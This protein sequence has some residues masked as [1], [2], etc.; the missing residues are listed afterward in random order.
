LLPNQLSQINKAL[1]MQVCTAEPEPKRCRQSSPL[2]DGA[3]HATNKSSFEDLPDE[4]VVSILAQLSSS[5]ES[6]ADLAAA[7][8]V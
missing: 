6:P 5:A 8:M 7:A 3:A 2:R 1:A 4:M